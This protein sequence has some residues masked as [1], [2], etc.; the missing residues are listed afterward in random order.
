MPQD[1]KSGIASLKVGPDIGAAASAPL[2]DEPRF[3]IR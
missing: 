3:D 1:R 2:T